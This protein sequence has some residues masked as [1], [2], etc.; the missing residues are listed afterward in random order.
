MSISRRSFVFGSVAASVFVSL[1]DIDPSKAEVKVGEGAEDK[2]LLMKMVRDIY[3]HDRF[4]EG[5]YDRTTNDVINKGNDGAAKK[6]M[7]SEGI[8]SLKK[9]KYGKV[10]GTLTKQQK[11]RAEYLDAQE[12]ALSQQIED[13]ELDQLDGAKVEIIIPKK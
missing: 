7:M 1:W 12:I 8:D 2:K 13:L 3:P 5:P 11:L 4:P 10:D 9:A 6:A